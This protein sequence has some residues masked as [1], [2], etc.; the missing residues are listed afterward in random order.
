MELFSVERGRH[1]RGGGVLS[2]EEAGDTVRRD[3]PKQASQL[4]YIMRT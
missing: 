2:A 1:L 4:A 3:W